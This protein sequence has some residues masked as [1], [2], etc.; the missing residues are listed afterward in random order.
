MAREAAPQP[1]LPTKHHHD[2]VVA[3]PARRGVKCVRASEQVSD[4][5][6][7][8]NI[9]VRKGGEGGR[10]EREG[11]GE[12]ERDKESICVVAAAVNN[13]VWGGH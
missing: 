9:C 10:S 13:N 2:R 7:C 12:T 5:K 11:G 3:V 1:V 8:V 4:V 6:I